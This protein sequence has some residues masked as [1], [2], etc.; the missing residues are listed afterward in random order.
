MKALL[1]KTWGVGNIEKKYHDNFVNTI[2]LV[3][4][5]WKP[6]YAHLVLTL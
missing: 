5:I 4:N 3:Y 2:T 1:F 6:I